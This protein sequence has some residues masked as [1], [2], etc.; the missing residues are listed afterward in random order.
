[1]AMGGIDMALWDARAKACGVPLVTLL[2]GEP[3]PI[4]AN[5]SLRTMSP[6]EAAQEAEELLALGFTALKI[7]IGRGDLAED[8]ATIRAVRRAVGT[9]IKLMVDYNQSLSVAEAVERVRVL[10]EEKLFWRK[11]F[12]GLRNPPAPTTS[13]GTP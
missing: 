13:R 4:P 7:K 12:S 6:Q 5:A 10:D 9:G 3:R 2:G 11:S 1:M 8:L